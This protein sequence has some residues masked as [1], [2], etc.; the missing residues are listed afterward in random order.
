MWHPNKWPTTYNKLMSVALPLKYLRS[1]FYWPPVAVFQSIVDAITVD[2][3][4]PIV[5]VL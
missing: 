5:Y 3:N 1:N 2:E 4:R